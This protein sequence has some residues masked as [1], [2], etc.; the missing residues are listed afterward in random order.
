MIAEPDTCLKQPV[1]AAAAAAI[2]ADSDADV[3]FDKTIIMSCDDNILNSDEVVRDNNNDLMLCVTDVSNNDGDGKK[4]S[5]N[6]SLKISIKNREIL[7][8]RR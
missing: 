7:Q 4:I 5:M 3:S 2:A 1:A 6:V 8:H